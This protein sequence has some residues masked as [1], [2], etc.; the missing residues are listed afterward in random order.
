MANSSTSE[1]LPEALAR[2][3]LFGGALA[4]VVG[5]L[6]SIVCVAVPGLHFI[7]GPLGPFVGG[8]VVGR[9]TLGAM[10]RALLGATVMAAGMAAIA[11]AFTGVLLGEEPSSGF[12]RAAP[13]IV[14]VY[15]GGLASFGAFVGAATASR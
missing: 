6:V 2:L 7:L 5:L 14:F 13:A 8:F 11:A 12:A 15:T 1:S 9:L 3:G 4:G 10:S